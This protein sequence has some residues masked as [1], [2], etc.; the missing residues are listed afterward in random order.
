[1]TIIPDITIFIQ[2][3]NFLIV[4]WFLNKF[5]FKPVLGALKKREGTIQTL[6][7]RVEKAKQSA[8]DFERQYDDVTHEKK[9]PII[10]SKDAALSEANTGATKLIE[11]ARQELTEELSKIKGEIETEGKKVYETL[12]ADVDRLS[13]DVAAKILRRSL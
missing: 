11:K 12:R 1:M 9:K 2:F 13:G 3:L 5:L 10:E 8:K 7:Q 6:A 4:L